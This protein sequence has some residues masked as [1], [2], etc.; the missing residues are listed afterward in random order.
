MIEAEETYRQLSAKGRRVATDAFNGHWSPDGKRLA[1]SVGFIGYSG[2]AVFDS[3]SKETELLIVQARTRSGHPTG[4]TS[5]LFGI[6]RF[7]P[8]PGLPMLNA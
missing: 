1:L 5:P 4:S 8:F 3:V 7:S 2:V 6:A